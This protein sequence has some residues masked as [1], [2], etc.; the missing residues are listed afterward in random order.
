MKIKPTTNHPQVRMA[1]LADI[2]PNPKNPRRHSEKAILLLSS[3]IERWGFL[4]PIIV[5]EHGNIVAGHARYLAAKRLGLDYVPVIEARFV[6]EADR[7]AF[8]LADNKIAEYSGWDN[9]LLIEELNFLVDN[10]YDLDITGFTVADLDFTIGE[11]EKPLEAEQVELPNPAA[12]AVSRL[13]DLWIIGPHRLLCGNSLEAASYDILLG[14]ERAHMVFADSPYNVKVD[15]H[16][17]GLGKT[18]HREFQFASGE[19]SR[20]EFTSFLR[21]V[22]RNCVT[23]SVSGSIHYQCMDWRHQREMLDAYEGV[24]SEYKQL[25]VW[26]KTN[27]GMGTFYR[28]QHELIYVFKSGKGKHTNNFGLGETGR[29][30]SNLW[31]YEGANTFRKGRDQDLAAHA[32]VKPTALVMDAILDCSN[33]GEIIL[34]PFSGSGTTLS[35]AHRTGRRGAAIEIDPLY[36]DTALARL[37]HVSGLTPIHADG[38]TF[39]QVAADR[40]SNSEYDN[41]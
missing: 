19:M 2:K 13:G 23:Y 5:D 34:D 21:S 9:T 38:R 20:P 15:G 37:A 8:A 1:L 41:D 24:Y 18:K 32:T 27:A 6:S 39:D 17:S 36:V 11:P 25:I 26:A 28:S 7:R 31:T 29:Y 33:R 16:V 4:N 12:T 30:R 10:H 22:F 3:G 35:A 14:S 40:R